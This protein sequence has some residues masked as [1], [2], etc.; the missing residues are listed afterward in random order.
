MRRDDGGQAAVPDWAGP[1]CILPDGCGHAAACT[2][3]G[4]CC[5]LPWAAGGRRA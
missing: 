3:A 1:D 2:I 4:R 5:G